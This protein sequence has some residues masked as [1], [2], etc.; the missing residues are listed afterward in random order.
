[1]NIKQYPSVM[2]CQ[3]KQPGVSLAFATTNS[4]CMFPPGESVHVLSDSSPSPFFLSI[5]HWYLVSRC[6]ISCL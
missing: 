4:S 5:N 3:P 6:S 1:M 2:T